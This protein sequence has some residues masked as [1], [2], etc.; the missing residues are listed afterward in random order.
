MPI[1]GI[2]YDKCINC[3][4]CLTACADP[5]RFFKKDEKE[6]KVIFEDPEKGCILCG[7]CI[8]QCPEDAII[9]ENVGE[10]FTFENVSTPEKIISF[11]IFYNFISANRSVRRYKK[12]KVPKEILEK[13]LMAM[14]RAPTAA[15]MR[16]EQFTVLSDSQKIKELNDAIRDEFYK[17]PSLKSQTE[18]QFEAFGKFFNSPIYY[19][20]PH[21]I[22]VTSSFNMMM[23]GFNIGIIVTYGRLAAQALGLGTCWN[24]YTEMAMRQFPQLKKLLKLRGHVVGTFTIGYPD[25]KYHRIP[26]RPMNKVKYIE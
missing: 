24:G 20:A 25:V 10:S 16:S 23:E 9:Y 6:D 7:Q 12:E 14:S 22:F 2:D 11:D 18:H 15:N 8:A 5:G 13:V 26:P 21:I 3:G 1:L 4:T 19:D 17:D